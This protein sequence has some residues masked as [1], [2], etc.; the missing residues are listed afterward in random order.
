MPGNRIAKG[1]MIAP[2]VRDCMRFDKLHKGAV[3]WSPVGLGCRTRFFFEAFLNV[4]P[5]HRR[6]LMQAGTL[7]RKASLRPI[8]EMDAVEKE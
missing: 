6:Q 8:V 3:E 7:S 4:C 5:F 2:C 1:E